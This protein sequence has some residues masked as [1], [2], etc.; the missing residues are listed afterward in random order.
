LD[1]SILQAL[2]ASYGFILPEMVLAAAACVLFLLSTFNTGRQAAG[3]FALASLAVAGYLHFFAGLHYADLAPD[4]ARAATYNGPLTPDALASLIRVIALS[5]GVVL[6]LFSWQEVPQRHHAD[7]LGCLLLTITGVSLAGAANDMI[8]LFLSL[9][10]VSIPTYI[11]LYLPRHDQATQEATMKYFLLSVFSSALTLF[12][13][14]Y[15]YGLAGTTNL[16]TLYDALQNTD[17]RDMPAVA[18]IAVITVIAG[19]GFRIT[20]VPFHFY[21]PDVYQGVAIIGAAFLAFIPKAAGIAA[22]L[23]VFGYVTPAGFVPAHDYVIGLALSPQV[24]IILWFLAVVTMFLGNI[25]ALLQDNVKRLLAYSSV[26]HAG[27]MLVALAVAPYL[28]GSHGFA[29][30]DAVEA[31]LYYLVAYGAMTVGA[32]AVLAYLDSPQ[33]RIDTVDDLAGLS[34]NHPVLALVMTLFLFSLIGIPLTAGFTG[35]FLVF[36]GAMSVPSP[37]HVWH[38]RTLAIL[39]MI[40]AAIG[41]WYYLRIVA[42]MYLRNPL[43]EPVVRRTVP[44]IGVLAICAVLTIGLSVQPGAQWLMD[45]ARAAAGVRQEAPATPAP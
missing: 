2:S 40:N 32:F 36:F 19:L 5:G 10:L 17:G 25:L 26:A 42:V 31:I 3:L 38:A 20:I 22:L 28:R 41:G 16:A 21:A 43:R 11:L 39:G 15:L 14:S 29:E 30:P 37:D 9:E 12:G 34:R 44:A 35:K 4:V 18:N 27:Y 45:A 24:P 23:R 1:D 7:F 13:F 6:V 33:S 8:V